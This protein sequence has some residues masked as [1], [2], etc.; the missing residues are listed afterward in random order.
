LGRIKGGARQVKG[1]LQKIELTRVKSEER[2]DRAKEY[3]PH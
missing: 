1:A 2:V 3:R